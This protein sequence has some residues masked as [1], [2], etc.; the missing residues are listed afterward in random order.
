MTLASPAAREP[1]LAAT[2]TP[3]RC[4][5][6]VLQCSAILTKTGRQGD[7][8]WGIVAD[9]RDQLTASI[10]EGLLYDAQ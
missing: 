9:E 7:S 3:E 5:R 4:T 6:A 10:G 2:E 1:R 8:V